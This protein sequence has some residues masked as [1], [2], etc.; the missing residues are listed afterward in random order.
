[1]ERVVRAGAFEKRRPTANE[2][3]DLATKWDSAIAD[4]L[5]KTLA[6]RAQ[7]VNDAENWRGLVEYDISTVCKLCATDESG[8]VLGVQFG[9]RRSEKQIV[10]GR[11]VD[12]RLQG[13]E[14]MVRDSGSEEFAAALDTI[15]QMSGAARSAL[16]YGRS[17]AVQRQ[18]ESLVNLPEGALEKCRASVSTWFGAESQGTIDSDPSEWTCAWHPSSGALTVHAMSYKGADVELVE[19]SGQ[20]GAELVLAYSLEVEPRW[21][22]LTVLDENG[23]G[24]V[25]SVDNVRVVLVSMAW[26]GA[27]CRPTI[28]VGGAG[29]TFIDNQVATSS[30]STEKGEI[31]LQLMDEDGRSLSGAKLTIQAYSSKGGMWHRG[32][33]A[34]LAGVLQLRRD[35]E[36]VPFDFLVDGGVV[37]GRTVRVYARCA[38]RGRVTW[39]LSAG[40]G[41][42]RVPVSVGIAEL[43]E[44]GYG[45]SGRVIEVFVRT[46]GPEALQ[47]ERV[48]GSVGLKRMDRVSRLEVY[49]M[50]LPQSGDLGW[51]CRDEEGRVLASGEVAA[52]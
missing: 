51:R 43:G 2:S 36:K 14:V 44:L 20:R 9:R 3:R 16:W 40:F 46:P 27:W 1:M 6:D 45:I 30:N 15:S 10:R 48:I 47:A 29:T 49:L 12:R 31:V 18:L 23:W 26:G 7:V 19:A 39:P 50:Q 5:A 4:L 38:G 21:L 24:L 52:L 11:V 33:R 22:G 35:F 34:N 25:P 28:V 32:G 41:E 42:L 13:L 37:E 8:G 17:V